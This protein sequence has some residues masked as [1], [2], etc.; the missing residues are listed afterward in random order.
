MKYLQHISFFL[1]ALACVA[2]GSCKKDKDSDDKEYLNGSFTLS[3]P[4]YLKY[5]D[6][7][8][9][10]PTGVYR[11]NEADTLLLYYWTNPLTGKNDTLRLEGEAADVSKE[12]DF[13]VN[14]DTIGTFSLSL[15][16]SAKGYYLK[17]ASAK[18]TI[19]REGL[20]GG[21]L[22]GY[23]FLSS[24]SETA[25]ARDGCRYYY[26]NVGGRDWM[27]QN[28]AWDGSGTAYMESGQ[29]STIFGRYYN[30]DEA[31]A[32]CPAGWRLPTDAEFVAL[33]QAGGGVPGAVTGGAVTGAAGA[34]L[35]DVR[36]NGSKMWPLSANVKISNSTR[37]SAIPAGYA[38]YD[39][40]SPTFKDLT[41][42]LFWTADVK[43]DD[44]AYARYLYAD[45]P[46]L[47][48]GAFGRK[49]MLASVRCVR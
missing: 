13:E 25:D 33:A 19:V 31:N 44:E 16:C 48:G 37:F 36:F 1:L 15:Y 21:S 24:L 5:G 4:P 38:V 35:M 14:V 49:T 29:M 46:D 10:N 11:E 28:L 6:K 41:Y 34:M 45:K 43:D 23:D 9:V 27:V 47:Y 22:G 32:A 12:F 7:V 2:A 3:V 17:S 39:G 18:F 42:A 30:W 20:Q 8:H 40:T 26:T